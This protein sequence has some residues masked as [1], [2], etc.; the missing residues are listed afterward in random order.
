MTILFTIRTF[1]IEAVYP[2]DAGTLVV[3]SQQKEVLR[4]FDFVGEQQTDSLQALLASINVVTKEQVISLWWKPS[5]LEES[6]QICVL[7]MDVT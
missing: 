1:I 3:S 7:A 4:I 6:Q 5:V 2:V